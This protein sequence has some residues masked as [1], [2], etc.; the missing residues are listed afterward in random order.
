[1]Q[2]LDNAVRA[3]EAFDETLEKAER[4]ERLLDIYAVFGVV[5]ILDRALQKLARDVLGQEFEVE[6][7][8]DLHEFGIVRRFLSHPVD[9]KP[10]GGDRRK[11]FLPAGA[12]ITEGIWHPENRRQGFLVSVVQQDYSWENLRFKP[13]FLFEYVKVL[14]LN[15]E[16]YYLP[17][18]LFGLNQSRSEA[19]T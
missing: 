16:N 11:G 4:G 9:L 5:Y 3:L 13:F 6:S 1:M 8:S 14:K 15:L 7:E 12:L 18:I 10:H 17:E 2:T 19:T